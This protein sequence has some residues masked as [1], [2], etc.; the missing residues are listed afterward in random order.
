MQIK[1][2]VYT[3]DD[4]TEGI[5]EGMWEYRFLLEDNHIRI[6]EAYSDRGYHDAYYQDVLSKRIRELFEFEDFSGSSSEFYFD[7]DEIEDVED[8]EESIVDEAIA[9]DDNTKFYDALACATF[10]HQDQVRKTSGTPYIAHLLSVAALVLESRGNENQ[11][12]AALLHD[13]VE[14]QGVTIDEI[15][16]RFGQKVADLVDAVTESN[17]NP[18]P[19]WTQRKNLYLSKLRNASTEAVLISL[20]DKLHNAR[21]LEEGLY[22]HGEVMWEKFFKSRKSETLWFYRELTEIYCAKGFEANWL[23]IELDRSLKRIFK[24]W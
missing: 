7:D 12:I 18:K 5:P 1:A 21:A 2:R 17:T 24:E 9:T 20:A 16:S 3:S 19:D 22:A 13:S 14:D 23:F 11:A 4:I 8:T 15:A 6:V 10:L